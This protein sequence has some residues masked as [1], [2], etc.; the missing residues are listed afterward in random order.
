MGLNES[1]FGVGT[2]SVGYA[3]PLTGMAITGNQPAPTPG[4]INAI[5]QSIEEL[6]GRL[7]A[8]VEHLHSI[9]DRLF[10]PMPQNPGAE[11]A[12]ANHLSDVGKV[13]DALGNALRLSGLLAD[14]TD[15]LSRL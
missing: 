12:K 11:A 3:G 15:R 7:S 2:G 13:H 8:N 1:R 6:N 14:A 5:R 4:E 10:G 9:A